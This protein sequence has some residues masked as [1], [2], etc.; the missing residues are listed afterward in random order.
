[1]YCQPRIKPDEQVLT[2]RFHIRN[3][4]A[5]QALKRHRSHVEAG[6]AAYALAQRG[7]G[8]PEGV[9]FRHD[10]TGQ[11]TR[12]GR[13]APAQGSTVARDSGWFQSAWLGPIQP[14]SPSRLNPNAR[15]LTSLRVEH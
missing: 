7:G 8:S 9:A 14:W 6:L 3:P 11:A 5:Y 1:M 12:D 10:S 15:S 2:F 4:L 13:Q